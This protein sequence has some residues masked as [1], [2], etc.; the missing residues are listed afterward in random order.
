MP[1]YVYKCDDCSVY[2]STSHSISEDPKVPCPKCKKQM[3]RVPQA[4]PASF[5]GEGFYTT[6]KFN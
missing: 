2:H 6:D 5:K 1:H 4:T 3:H